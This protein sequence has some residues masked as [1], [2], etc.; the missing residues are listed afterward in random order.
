MA[1]VEE[2]AGGERPV[3]EIVAATGLPQPSVSTQLGC[4]WE[5]GLVARERRG[6]QVHY[7]L[8]EGVGELLSVSDVILDR[9]G[10]TVGACPKYG[11]G[12]TAAA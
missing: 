7:R 10:K 3:G 4:L 11:R 5:C 8:V 12:G 2:L 9:A 1:I 6:R